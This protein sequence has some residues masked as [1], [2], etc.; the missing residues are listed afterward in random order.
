MRNVLIITY[1]WPPSGGS[2]VQRWLKM[3]KYLPENGWRPIIYTADNAEYPVLDSSLEKD[4]HNEAVVIRRP[5]VEPYSFYKKFLGMKKNETVKAGF[6]REK[7]SDNHSFSWKE[8]FSQWIR[9]NFFIPDARCWWIRPSAKYLL[10]YLKDHPVDVI[11]STG[12][13]HS[14]HLIA[15]KIHQK[16]NIP[17]IA[18]FRDP[19]TDIDFYKDL[20]LTKC[21]DKKHH[22]LEKEVLTEANLVVTVGKT[23]AENLAKTADRKVNVIHNGF[24][25]DIEENIWKNNDFDKGK[26]FTLSH[27]GILNKDRNALTL[28][29]VLGEMVKADVD[30]ANDLRIRL[31]G[32]VDGSVA[33]A[34]KNNGLSDNATVIENVPHQ[35]AI[36]EQ[37]SATVLL[38]LI[39][40]SPNAKGILTGKI[41]E[42]LAS[43]RPILAIGPEDGDTAA[44]LNET[45]HGFIADFDN[46]EKIKTLIINFYKKFKNNDLENLEV[47]SVE[48]YSRKNL[49]KQYVELFEQVAKR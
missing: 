45:K 33:D 18:D 36:R 42:Y 46:E 1:Y 2:G 21:A 48:K 44:V 28:W 32:Q 41:F 26:Y 3:S 24:D 39:N 11:V 40:N 37:A 7:R 16:T 9:G 4:I 29:K 43:G 35:E 30:F 19:W 14:M 38:L 22:Q 17:W 47:V 15:K 10:S 49:A 8:S 20:H 25:F 6:I 34:L 12:P 13:P 5:I 27:I 31:I 23:W